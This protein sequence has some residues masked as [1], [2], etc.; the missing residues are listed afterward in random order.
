MAGLTTTIRPAT[1]RDLDAFVEV[2]TVAFKFKNVRPT[3]HTWAFEQPDAYVLVAEKK[4]RI[5]ATGA[6]LGFGPTGW[7]G[8]IA[9]RPEAR[10]ERLGTRMTEAA[11]EA[12]GPRETLLLLASPLGRPIYEGMGFE[13]DGPYRVFFGPAHAKP[14]PGDG[15][16][17]ATAADHARI[18]ELDRLA[19]GEDRSAAVASGLDRALVNGAGFALRPPFPARPIVATDPAAGRALLDATLAPGLRVAVPQA[20]APAVEALLAHGCEERHGVER[21]RLGAPVA[22]RPELIWGVFSLFFG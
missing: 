19:T 10:G 4:G 3:V 21:M 2:M 15:I 8:A 16:R 12:L 6:S 17:E 18:F 9:V 11:I 5:V 1:A 20:N 13:P 7:I 14:A 22:W